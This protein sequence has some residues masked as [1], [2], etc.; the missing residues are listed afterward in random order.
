MARPLLR[1]S[2]SQKISV[3]LDDETLAILQEIR[4]RQE[5]DTSLSAA[6]RWAVLQ[7]S[8]Q[9]RDAA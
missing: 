3:T 7:Q 5:C 9:N 8:R 2:K 1:R 6:L 4:D